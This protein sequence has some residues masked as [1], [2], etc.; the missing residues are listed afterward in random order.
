MIVVCGYKYDSS[1]LLFKLFV[2]EHVFRMMSV[3]KDQVSGAFSLE[4]KI[5]MYAQLTTNAV[6]KRVFVL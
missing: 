5:L 2:R 4:M 1:L 6:I 3:L